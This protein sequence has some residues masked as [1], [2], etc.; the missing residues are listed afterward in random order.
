M[1]RPKFFTDDSLAINF[2]L[3]KD[4]AT[5]LIK[6]AEENNEKVSFIVRSI[7]KSYLDT[8]SSSASKKT[9]MKK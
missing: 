8:L 4:Y 1:G 3:E 7:I 9:H 6:I 2:K 5:Q